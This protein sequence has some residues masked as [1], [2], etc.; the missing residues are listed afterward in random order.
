VLQPKR[1]D[2]PQGRE[3]AVGAESRRGRLVE[4]RDQKFNRE[5]RRSKRTENELFSCSIEMVSVT[6]PV[7]NEQE[8]HHYPSSLIS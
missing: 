3:A 1:T 6:V 7:E 2:P 5:I 8:N 4:Q